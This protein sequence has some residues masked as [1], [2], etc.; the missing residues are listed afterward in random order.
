M[1]RGGIRAG[2]G[3]KRAWETGIADTAIKIPADLAEAV[4]IY[5]RLLDSG[6]EAAWEFYRQRGGN[7]G[8]ANEVNSEGSRDSHESA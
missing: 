4:L 5:A 3:R 6:D 7:N 1:A 8:Q 2:S